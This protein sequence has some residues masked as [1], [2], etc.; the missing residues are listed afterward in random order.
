MKK[1]TIELIASVF[2]AI[3]FVHLFS[4]AIDYRGRSAY[5]PL[6][7]AG[8]GFVMCLFW[9]AGQVLQ[10]DNDALEN[11]GANKSDFKRFVL[12][13]VGTVIYVIAFARIGFLTS[14]VAMIPALALALGYQNWKVMIVTAIGFCAVIYSVFRLLLSIPLPKEA[15]L[16]LVG[17]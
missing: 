6:A 4:E 5:M 11:V 8:C 17:M 13:I 10:P 12:L 15:I 9:A 14:T 1:R 2:F 7:A 16:N 3:L